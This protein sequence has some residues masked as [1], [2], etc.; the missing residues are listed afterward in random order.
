MAL[1][2]IQPSNSNTQL[3]RAEIINGRKGGSLNH[4]YMKR[5]SGCNTKL[6]GKRM[7]KKINDGNTK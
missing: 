7:E 3:I 6:R 1:R 2:I 5:V 4:N